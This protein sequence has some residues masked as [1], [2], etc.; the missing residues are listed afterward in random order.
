MCHCSFQDCKIKLKKNS[1]N[2]MF[3]CKCEKYYCEQHIPS[4]IHNCTYLYHKEKQQHLQSKMEDVN[5][6][7]I[8][9]I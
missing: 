3:P 2:A 1:L 9:K 8:N 4:Y 6:V 5:F 7:K